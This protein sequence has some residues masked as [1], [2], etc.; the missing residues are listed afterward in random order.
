MEPC[1]ETIKE[2]S[3]R[4]VKAQRPIRVLSAINWDFRIKEEFFAAGFKEQPAVDRSF[5]ESRKLRLDPDATREELRAVEADIVG[6]LGP[7]SVPGT[8]M[9][10]MCEQLRLTVDMIEARGTDR[11]SSISG[12]LYGTPSDVFHAGG[13][14]VA[15]LAK[16]MRLT[17]EANAKG[18]QGL[19][20]DRTIPGAEAAAILQSQLDQSVGKGLIEVRVD[21]DLASDAAAGRKSGVR[22]A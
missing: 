8:M 17:L 15:D 5:Y 6:R 21:T 11:F 19:G 7:I 22:G 13:P 1:H 4:I 10:F 12:L 14:T 2:L 16:E 3:D 18:I 9:R 20:D